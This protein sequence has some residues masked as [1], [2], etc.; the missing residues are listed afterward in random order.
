[1]SK[2]Q[3]KRLSE[4]HKL[5][6]GPKGT[7]GTEAKS[8]EATV[9]AAAKEVYHLENRYP[10]LQFRF[11]DSLSKAEINKKLNSIDSRLGKVLFVKEANI[12]PDGG[13]IEVKDKNEQWRI[14]LASEAK[15][16]GMD[17][18]NIKAG[19][20]VGK[21][22]NQDLMV[23]GNAI[24]R[25]HKNINEIRNF[26]LA[27]KHFPY[28]VFLQGSNFSTETIKIL[29]PQGRPVLIRHDSGAMNRI[30]RVTSANYGM[31]INKNHCKNIIIKMKD[32]Y[33]MLQ[34]AFIYARSAS[35][36]KEEMVK[37]MD[38]IVKT[39]LKVISSELPKPK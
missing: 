23:A 7:F 13:I 1:M 19:I 8:H 35:W 22:K 39:S 25:V 27:E 6:G 17:V 32:Y 14:I 18:N 34:C 28:I 2:G 21:N 15:H 20:K 3:A 9:R 38:N 33:L 10:N 30:D 37:I 11:R 31:E 5:A 36:S 4:E 24:E 29:D 26:M 16:Q 12:K